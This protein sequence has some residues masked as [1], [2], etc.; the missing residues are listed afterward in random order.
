[1]PR[2]RFKRFRL[3]IL[4]V[5]LISTVVCTR[6]LQTLRPADDWTR[7]HN[8]TF[9]VNRV[10]DGDTLDIDAPDKGKPVTRIRLWGVDTP[11]VAKS[12]YGEMHFGPE[13]SAFAKKTL[14]GQRV[15][16]VLAP[17]KSRGKYGRLLAYVYLQRGGTMFNEMLLEQGYAYADY[18]FKHPYKD[19]FKATEKR[20]R[21]N[22][23][24]LWSNITL[25]KMPKWKQRF[26]QRRQRKKD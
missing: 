13:A 16:I 11:E 22:G 19:Q 18:R 15:H 6:S 7:Y 2:F 26:E 1:M 25:E 3:L 14:D 24:G 23:I 10:V 5:L 21:R 4:T 9:S 12:R 17:D 20:A 8:K